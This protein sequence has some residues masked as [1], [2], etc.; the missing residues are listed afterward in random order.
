MAKVKAAGK[1]RQEGKTYV[2]KDGDII[3]WQFSK[4]D[5]LI[6]RCHYQSPSKEGQVEKKGIDY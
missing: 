6:Y 1:Y 4:F 2:V 3:F 5:I